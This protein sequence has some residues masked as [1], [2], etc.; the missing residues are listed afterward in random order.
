[1]TLW[2]F[3]QIHCAIALLVVCAARP[4]AQAIDK[5]RVATIAGPAL[6]GGIVSELVW[7]EGTLVIQSAIMDDGGRLVPRYYVA[8][9][10]GTDVRKLPAVPAGAEEY[11]KMK[12][13]RTSP[14][15]LGRITDVKDAKIAVYGVGAI[16]KR[17]LEAQDSGGTENL[18]ELRLGR[19]T[20]YSSREREPYDGEVWSWSPARLN[21][22]AY[23]DGRGDIWIARADGT[24]PERIAR[25]TFTLPAWSDDGRSIAVAE[26]KDGGTRW[27]VSVIHLP[28]RFRE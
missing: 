23:V 5:E 19:L 16:E 24:S 14:T 3:R 1:M 25:G 17:L 22:I 2:G 11:W 6:A 15:G 28:Q 12:A 8:G 7:D 13:S 4:A 10:P 21:R 26:R 18:F 20:L 27:E 9:A